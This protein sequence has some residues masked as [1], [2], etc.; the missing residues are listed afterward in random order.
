MKQETVSGSGIS[1]AIC[2]S[3]PSSR[4]ITT[5]AP[6]HSVFTGRMP[7]L[8]P[9]QQRQ[10]TEGKLYAY[11]CRK[12]CTFGAGSFDN[13]SRRIRRSSSISWSSLDE[14]SEWGSQRLT[15]PSTPF[16]ATQ[17]IGTYE[18][19]LFQRPMRG[20]VLKHVVHILRS[21][22][23][24]ISISD[25]SHQYATIFVYADTT[26]NGSPCLPLVFQYIEQHALASTPVKNWMILLKESF[27]ATYPR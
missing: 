3:A 16:T 6:H 15:L 5:P 20:Y 26:Q 17:Y 22:D 12:S 10:S 18:H 1:W 24:H 13:C 21:C 2:K 19:N 23:H 11:D 7:F 25:N 9:N 14:L 27:A 8:P 4:Q